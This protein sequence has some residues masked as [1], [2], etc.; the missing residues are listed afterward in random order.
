MVSELQRAGCIYSAMQMASFLEP[1]GEVVR[2]SGA[3][4]IASILQ[5]YQPPCKKQ[6][7]E[8]EEVLPNNSSN[9]AHEAIVIPRLYKEQVNDGKVTWVNALHSQEKVV[10]MQQVLLH[11]IDK[12]SRFTNSYRLWRSCTFLK[13][14]R[15]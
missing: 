9:E 10:K 11:V 2:D 15:H 3:D 13:C 7:D 8:E 12:P 14:D 5:Q 4:I 6:M 1:E